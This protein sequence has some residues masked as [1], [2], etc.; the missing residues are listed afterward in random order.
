MGQFLL[1]IVD[2]RLPE[3]SFS[4]ASSRFVSAASSL[5]CLLRVSSKCNF[6]RRAFSSNSFKRESAASRS[7]RILAAS[8]L[9][10]FLA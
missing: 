9:S 5:A 1:G 6:A 3:L 8:S 10:F 7:K 4:L 2:A